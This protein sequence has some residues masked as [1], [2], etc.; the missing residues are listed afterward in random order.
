[1]MEIFRDAPVGQVIRRVSKNRHLQYPE[2]KPGFALP[3]AWTRIRVEAKP[4]DLD[5]EN[6][7]K[8]GYTSDAGAVVVGWYD[9]SDAANP[10]NWSNGKRAVVSFIIWFYTFTVYAT[11]SIYINSIA[12]IMDEFHVG[13]IAATL[14]FSL[15]V[16]G[17]GI[18]PMVFSPLG[19]IEAVGR[20]PTYIVTMIVFV[21]ISIPASLTPTYAGLLVLR[22]LQGIFGSPCLATG[23]ATVSDM[24]SMAV[25]PYAMLAWVS[26]SYFARTFL[27][28][29]CPSFVF[30]F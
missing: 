24:Y 11:A 8:R 28:P 12:G 23:G 22:F 10:R 16:L 6:A 7:S 26:A 27:L 21:V 17:Y 9:D 14:G 25:L 30:R 29:F 5:K 4:G 19:E 18:G 20:N 1:M 15:Y 2:E 13:Q 3:S